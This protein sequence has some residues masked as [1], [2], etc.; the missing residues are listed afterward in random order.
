MFAAC[1]LHYM[2][3]Q[4]SNL[5]RGGP[6]VFIAYE[7]RACL[8][9]KESQDLCA[10]TIVQKGSL[11]DVQWATSHIDRPTQVL[12]VAQPNIE[13][14]RTCESSSFQR[15]DLE[16]NLSMRSEHFPNPAQLQGEL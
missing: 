15:G 16:V 8:A 3:A 5:P 2:M 9:L 7:S 12:G 1:R 6:F 14:I 13:K 4:R 10:L 11:E